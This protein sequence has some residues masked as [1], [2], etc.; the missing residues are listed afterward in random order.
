[1]APDQPPQGEDQG[2]GRQGQQAMVTLSAVDVGIPA[3][4]ARAPPTALLRQ[5]ALRARPLR[6]IRPPHQKAWLDRGAL[7][8]GG[9]AALK[10]DQEPAEEGAPG[11]SVQRPGGARCQRRSRSQ[12]AGADFSGSLRLMAVVATP[13]A[14][15]CRRPKSP[16]PAARRRARHTTLPLGGRLGGARARRA[17]PRRR[18]QEPESGQQRRRPVIKNGEQKVSLRTS[19]GIL[20]IPLKPAAPS[21]SPEVQVKDRKPADEAGPAPTPVRAAGAGPDAAPAAE[22]PL[23]REP[24]ESTGNSGR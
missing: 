5:A 15:A 24:G 10:A 19:A 9:D 11:R 13:N 18:Q 2:A 8:W 17:Q 22:P 23:H 1:M 14:S 20:R 3:S 6:T 16:S 7:K 21:A 12:P 4:P